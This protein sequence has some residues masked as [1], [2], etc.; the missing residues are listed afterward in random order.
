MGAENLPDLLVPALAPEV[1][2]DLADARHEAVGVAGGPV[3]SAAVGRLE[4]VGL[5][6]TGGEALPQSVG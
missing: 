5:T 6:V 2:V 1:Q 4:V 3:G